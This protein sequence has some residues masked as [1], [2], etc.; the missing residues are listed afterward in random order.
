VVKHNDLLYCVEPVFIRETV[1]HLDF[2]K[3]IPLFGMSRP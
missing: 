2:M 1:H 3:R